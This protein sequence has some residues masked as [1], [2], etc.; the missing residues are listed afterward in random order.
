[1]YEGLKH[2]HLLTIAISATLLSVR[3]AMMMA[4][5]KLLE[6]KFFKVFPHINDTCLLL[7]GIGLIFITGF[8]PFT[9]AAPWLT[10]KITCVLAYIA[11]GFFALK[12]G[13]NKLLRTFSFFG[14]LGWLAMAGKVAVSKA[15]L[16]LG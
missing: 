2:F 5:S 1:M 6:K 15:P 8:I 7:S 14:A 11:L 12:L 9:A 4:N 10:E 3:Y 16:F 13:K